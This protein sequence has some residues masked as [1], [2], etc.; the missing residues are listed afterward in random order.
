MASVAWLPAA[1][2]EIDKATKVKPNKKASLEEDLESSLE[3]AIIRM[4]AAPFFYQ[5]C[6]VDLMNMF[7]NHMTYN[8]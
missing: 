1:I 5:T 6:S 8:N 4:A 7:H 2:R 3:V